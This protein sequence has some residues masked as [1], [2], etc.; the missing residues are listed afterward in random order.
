MM[1]AKRRVA[2]AGAVAATAVVAFA[3]T[4]NG[5]SK[6]A[7]D[8]DNGGIKLPEGFCALVVANDLGPA[9]HLAVASNGDI[10]VAFQS[11]G[12]RGQPETGGGVV[13]PARCRRRRQVRSPGA[14]SARAA[15]RAWPCAMGISTS[16]TRRP[17]ER[18]KMTAGQLKPAG[19][20]EIVVTGLPPTCG[21]T[22]TRAS[23]STARARCTST[24]ARRATPVSSPIVSPA[25]R[26]R[27][28]ARFSR[29]TAASG[30]STRTSSDQTQDQGTRFAT[31]LR[32]MPAIT[33]HDER[34]LHRDEQPRSARFLLAGQVHGGGQRRP[35][36]RAAVSRRTGRRDFGW[37]YCFYDY[38]QKKCCSI[39]STAATARRSAAA[40]SSPSRSRA[41]PPTGR[42]WT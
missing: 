5:Q 31:G 24:S 29:S 4:V 13:A 14:D 18:F 16:R 8:P 2:G 42:R 38:A 7:C 33:W 27:I 22:T 35:S 11:R 23:R 6:I 15:R 21:S 32:Q 10:Y 28:P 34:P 9:R 12:G 36:G 25:R 37:P 30:S 1:S 41:S 39:P 3:L 19:A 20:A 40:R 17:I 26:V